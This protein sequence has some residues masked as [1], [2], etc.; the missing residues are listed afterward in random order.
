VLPVISVE[1]EYCYL[2]CY[3]RCC[4]L[5]HPE[6]ED[7]EPVSPQPTIPAP[8]IP[9]PPTTIAQPLNITAL[10][11]LVAQGQEQFQELSTALTRSNVSDSIL[12]DLN[13][14]QVTF[15]DIRGHLNGVASGTQVIQ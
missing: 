2:V 3:Y 12:A 15:Q 10:R 11:S 13:A 8:T 6:P 4:F 1:A 7:S 14:I 9:A 5:I